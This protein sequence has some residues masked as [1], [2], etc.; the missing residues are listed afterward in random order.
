MKQQEPKYIQ[1]DDWVLFNGSHRCACA[2]GHPLTALYTPSSLAQ[3][4]NKDATKPANTK[5]TKRP[6]NRSIRTAT[7]LKAC[8][9]SAH[10]G[11]GGRKGAKSVGTGNRTRV[12]GITILCTTIILFRLPETQKICV[13]T[14]HCTYTQLHTHSYDVT[15]SVRHVVGC[16]GHDNSCMQPATTRKQPT[17]GTNSASECGKA[18]HALQSLSTAATRT[19]QHKL[20]MC[21]GQREHV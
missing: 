20:Q 15:A 17:S 21:M 2:P 6:Q 18:R 13:H 16:I 14:T 19:L 4:A 8:K 1:K 7:Q 9:S 12:T 11:M 5:P 10:T 3:C